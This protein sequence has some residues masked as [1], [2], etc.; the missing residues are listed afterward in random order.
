VFLKQAV[1]TFELFDNF[2]HL[3]YEYSFAV[4]CALGMHSI[5]LAPDSIQF[6]LTA[7]GAILC[8]EL[9]INTVIGIPGDDISLAAS[10]AVLSREN[11][12]WQLWYVGSIWDFVGRPLEQSV[13]LWVKGDSGI[14]FTFGKQFDQNARGILFF[15]VA[16]QFDLPRFEF[17]NLRL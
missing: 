17:F 1:V 4:A 7:S 13:Y 16:F 12:R 8:Q 5:S 3:F 15:D 9:I 6:R 14:V 2:L 11:E 10:V